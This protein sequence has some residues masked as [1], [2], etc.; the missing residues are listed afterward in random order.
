MRK[1][2]PARIARVI[3]SL[4]DSRN[5]VIVC[6]VEG[7]VWLWDMINR[8]VAGMLRSKKKMSNRQPARTPFGPIKMGFK[9]DF[10]GE[11]G[12]KTPV[13]IVCGKA[14]VVDWFAVAI[15]FSLSRVGGPSSHRKHLAG[16]NIRWRRRSL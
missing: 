15:F 6:G 4:A 3:A 12:C 5:G 2:A 11:L 16:C 13:D 10:T 8:A 14:T 7:A 1:A 9:R